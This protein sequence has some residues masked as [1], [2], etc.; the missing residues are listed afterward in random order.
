MAEM[1]FQGRQKG[2]ITN[3]KNL[4]LHLQTLVSR[5]SPAMDVVPPTL[6]YRTYLRSS[7]TDSLQCSTKHLLS[8]LSYVNF[9]V[10]KINHYCYYSILS[11]SITQPDVLD[12]GYTKAQPSLS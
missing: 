10:V 6:D 1:T 3:S 9:Q 7:T 11:P 12:N 2:E 8:N 5:L 4:E